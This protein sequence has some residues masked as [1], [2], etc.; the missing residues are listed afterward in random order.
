[1]VTA[2]M[3]LLLSPIAALE[4]PQCTN[5]SEWG[6]VRYHYEQQEDDDDTDADFDADTYA[7][8]D[9]DTDAERI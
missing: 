7:D 3:I 5:V 6:P 9:A 2:R 4:T 8:S 1:M